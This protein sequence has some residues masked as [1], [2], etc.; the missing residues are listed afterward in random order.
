MLEKFDTPVRCSQGH[1]YTSYWVPLGSLKAIRLGGC[2]VQRCPVGHH[3][4][5]TYRVDPSELTAQEAAEAAATHDARI[6]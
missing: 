2:R 5:K 1:L 3:W 6:F 4:A